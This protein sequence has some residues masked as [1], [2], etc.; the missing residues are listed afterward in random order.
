MAAKGPPHVE[1]TELAE[2][3]G[4]LPTS[5]EQL[6]AD[7][8]AKDLA[9]GG[10]CVDATDTDDAPG[11][12]ERV[13]LGAECVSRVGRSGTDIGK[14]CCVA[15]DKISVGADHGD[16]GL[17]GVGSESKVLRIDNDGNPRPD[18]ASDF[19]DSGTV[20]A[21]GNSERDRGKIDLHVRDESS[22]ICGSSITSGADAASR[23]QEV[24]REEHGVVVAGEASNDVDAGY[25]DSGT[26][27]TDRNS[28][29]LDAV[30]EDC[31]TPGTVRVSGSLD[32]GDM[33]CSDADASKV[34]AGIG[35]GSELCGTNTVANEVISK[36]LCEACNTIGADRGRVDM[37]NRQ[38][39]GAVD[40]I[41]ASGELDASFHDHGKAD[42][43][44]AVDAIGA[45]DTDYEDR[46]ATAAAAM[47]RRI[48]SRGAP[49]AKLLPLPVFSKSRRRRRVRF[50]FHAV[51]VHEIPPYG[52]IYGAHPR[53][54]VFD[55]YS[56]RLPAAPNGYVSLLSVGD[57][58]G[59]EED[60]S[61]ASSDEEE[62]TIL[63]RGAWSAFPGDEV[64][65]GVQDSWESYLDERVEVSGSG[66][67]G[68]LTEDLKVPASGLGEL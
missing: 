43:D 30:F 48:A 64:E 57:R 9:T 20:V 29:C 63:G 55:R 7:V 58:D 52:D 33:V 22:S 25:E 44:G 6:G 16:R 47:L 21:A 41:R 15:I 12:D 45:L 40:A 54:F 59:D 18:G 67:G 27:D 17:A 26:A 3:V 42:A 62:V 23:I 50:D 53:T 35:V 13:E 5:G 1:L 49:A 11:A 14:V 2:L 66:I 65:F 56:R 24:R 36:S 46:G 68:S 34:W 19:E 31:S 39:C 4:P 60:P 28:S 51:T 10:V 32:V 61:G 37:D 38:D 8:P